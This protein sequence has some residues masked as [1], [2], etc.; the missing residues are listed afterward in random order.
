MMLLG[1]VIIIITPTTN[2]AS[3][4]AGAEMMTFFAPASICGWAFSL[5]A[6]IPVDS[7]TTSTPRSPHGRSPGLRSERTASF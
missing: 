3:H 7:I 4:D 2:V 1:I 5:S 6:K